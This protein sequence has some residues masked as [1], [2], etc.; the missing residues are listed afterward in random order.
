MNGP[1]EPIKVRVHLPDESP[2]AEFLPAPVTNP[3]SGIVVKEAR[4]P[5]GMNRKERRRAMRSLPRK[6]RKELQRQ[7]E[8]GEKANG[9][10]SA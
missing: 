3:D 2:I 10:K 4:S 7:R 8:S 1:R 5:H 9:S 6:V